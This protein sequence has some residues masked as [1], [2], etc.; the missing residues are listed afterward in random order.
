VGNYNLVHKLVK[1]QNWEY[2]PR[3]IPLFGRAPCVHSR[4]LHGFVGFDKISA[5]PSP[6]GVGNAYSPSPNIVEHNAVTEMAFL[7]HANIIK[8]SMAL[9][10]CTGFFSKWEINIEKY[11]EC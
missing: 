7:L 3:V 10:R 2:G 1:I 4:G 8:I 5:L 9:A 11:H 6:D